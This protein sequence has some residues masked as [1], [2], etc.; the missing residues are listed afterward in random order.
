MKKT[1]LV[2][3]SIFLSASVLTAP[4][5]AP[6]DPA[7]AAS[8]SQPQS[9]I[10]VQKAPE[11]V[12]IP[13]VEKGELRVAS[14]GLGELGNVMVDVV[15]KVK[16]VEKPEPPKAETLKDVEQSKGEPSKEKPKESYNSESKKRVKAQESEGTHRE[17]TEKPRRK[18]KKVVEVT[19]TTKTVK[20]AESQEKPAQK[21]KSK[22]SSQKKSSSSKKSDSSKRKKSNSGSGSSIVFEDYVVGHLKDLN[23][24]PC[25]GL[26][27]YGR[28]YSNYYAREINCKG[29]GAYLR[30]KKGQ[31]II[32]SGKTYE[33]A[34][35]QKLN[36]Y[37]DSMSDV[38]PGY[39]LY[40]QTCY[41]KSKGNV[42]VVAFRRV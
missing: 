34:S 31:R 42:R 10:E 38:Q 19:T 28:G 36:Y 33:V 41:P 32:V 5:V 4:Q 9:V 24:V 1:V 6:E 30:L 15:P 27:E 25:G 39:D 11:P 3:L 37:R 2:A 13:K 7:S 22:D 14:F 18:K 21:K 20:K 17:E 40:V 12:H 16:E 8:A 26:Y 23:N 35:T 29:S